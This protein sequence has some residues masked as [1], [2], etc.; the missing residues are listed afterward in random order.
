[1]STYKKMKTRRDDWRSKAV[2]AKTAL[3]YKK[4]NIAE[5]S[6]SVMHTSMNFVTLNWKSKN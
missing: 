5:L 2:T 3:R 6:V 1:M 4:K